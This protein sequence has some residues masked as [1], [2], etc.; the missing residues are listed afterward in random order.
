MKKD[1][2]KLNDDKTEFIIFGTPSALKQVKTPSIQIGDHV[3]HLSSCVRNIGAYCDTTLKMN[4]QVQHMCKSAWYHLYQIRKVQSYLTEDQ[5][6]T[7]V[8]AYVTSKL[9]TNNGLLCGAYKYLISKL[10]LV[11]NAAAKVICGLRKF[12]HATTNA[13]LASS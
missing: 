4:E 8:H 7:L 9:D 11:Q 1:K 12:D 10:Q 3:T 5:C 2:L 6:K 13:L